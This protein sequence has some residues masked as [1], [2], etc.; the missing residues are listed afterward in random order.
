[1]EGRGTTFWMRS[2]SF[3]IEAD[4]LQVVYEH[5]FISYNE[6]LEVFHRFTASDISPLCNMQKQ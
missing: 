4:L 1:M 5:W 6:N 3:F 2:S